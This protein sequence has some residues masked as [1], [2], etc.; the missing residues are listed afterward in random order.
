M[1]LGPGESF[2][3]FDVVR[4][5]GAGGMGEVYLVRHPR[6]PRQEALKV[7]PVD[8]T[9]DAGYRE[10]FNRE[11]ELAA[12]LYHPNVVGVH[13]RG[14][15]DGRLWISMDYVDGTDASALPK[16]NDMRGIS[17]DDVLDLIIPVAGALDYAHGKGM[18][19]RDVKPANILIADAP[20]KRVVL[21][22]FGIARR[23][24]D[25]SGLTGTDTAVGTVAYAAPEQLAGDHVDGRAD[26][27]A[28]AATAFTLLSGQVPFSRSGRAGIIARK[29]RGDVP[30]LDEIRPDLGALGTVLS[31]A[32]QRDPLLRFDTCTEFTEELFRASRGAR[33]SGGQSEPV[34]AE[35][36]GAKAVSLV[37]RGD[38][39]SDWSRQHL[40]PVV[41][42]VSALALVAALV[43]VGFRIGNTDETAGEPAS[44]PSVGA[45]NPL[46]VS[47]AAGKSPAAT[48]SASSPPLSAPATTSVA[49]GINNRSEVVQKALIDFQQT[50]SDMNPA[51]IGTGNFDPCGTLTAVL[52]YPYGASGSAVLHA[53]LF[54]KGRYVG[55]ATDRPYSGM[56]IDRGLSF[57]S[58]VALSYRSS[59]PTCNACDDAPREIIE[60]RWTGS[61]VQATGTPPAYGRG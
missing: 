24:D 35:I 12:S 19:H 25:D 11:A 13:D 58:T 47:K 48:V 22:D 7:L 6:L 30:Q 8:L 5:L 21:T 27:Y 43:F 18:I 36:S 31:R 50:H 41:V 32:L 33:S 16:A 1:P 34:T 53:M 49:C 54:N 61:S 38:R 45:A 17:V 29:M 59:Q 55:T 28:L 46:T 42:G 57:G 20:V 3:G 15:F 4:Q 51:A 37:Q 44:T 60:Y 26:Q 39:R 2:A 56:T 52:V 14:E 10:R 40:M 23:I 9:S